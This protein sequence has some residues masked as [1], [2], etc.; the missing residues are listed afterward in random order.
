MV[1]QVTENQIDC[2]V[3]ELSVSNNVEMP[4]ETR[5]NE[6]SSSSWWTHC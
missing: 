1:N 3:V 5:S 4:N 2:F 6:G